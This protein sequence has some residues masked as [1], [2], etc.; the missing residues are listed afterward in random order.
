[1]SR[2]KIPRHGRLQ[3]PGEAPQVDSSTLNGS[4]QVVALSGD[5]AVKNADQKGTELDVKKKGNFFDK[6]RRRSGR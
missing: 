3:S 4:V 6:L 1:M 2:P 5:S